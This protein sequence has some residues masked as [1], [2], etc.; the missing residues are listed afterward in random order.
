MRS[1]KWTKPLKIGGLITVVDWDENGNPARVAIC[2]D[3]EEEY[4]VTDDDV[5]EEL[6]KLEH[7]EVMAIGR[8]SESDAGARTITV[9]EYE[10]VG[11]G[12]L[13]DESG[14]ITFT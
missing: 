13:G 1:K 6:L 8:V 10:V 3:N 5:G 9:A 7:E 14:D 2:T 11:Y 12:S 4:L